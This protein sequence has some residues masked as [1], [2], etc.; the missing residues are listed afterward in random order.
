MRG[1]VLAC[2]RAENCQRP[3]DYLAALDFF[4]PLFCFWQ[5]PETPRDFQRC[6][7]LVCNVFHSPGASE[8][9]AKTFLGAHAALLVSA[10]ERQEVQHHER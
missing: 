6:I 9:L 10:A 3:A 7:L 2:V 5:G 4:P 8:W 1:L